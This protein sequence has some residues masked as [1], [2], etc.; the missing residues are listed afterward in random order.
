M[1]TRGENIK[2]AK[3]EYGLQDL[4]RKIHLTFI[5]Y[6]YK[7]YLSFLRSKKNNIQIF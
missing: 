2:F 6:F 7:I 4:S 1:I 5:Y 3:Q